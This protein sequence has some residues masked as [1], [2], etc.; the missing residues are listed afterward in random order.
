MKDLLFVR[1]YG[2][3]TRLLDGRRATTHWLWAA[4]LAAR[5]SLVQADP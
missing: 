3:L 2:V 5:Y 1:D 4:E